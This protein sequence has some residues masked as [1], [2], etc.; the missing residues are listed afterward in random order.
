MDLL[1]LVKSRLQAHAPSLA[2]VEIVEDIEAL[3][4]GT[5]AG[6]GATFVAPYREDAQPN[7]LTAGGF[8][9]VVTVEFLTAF[10]IRIA[11]DSK[12]SARIAR[13]WALKTEIER[14]LAGWQ[15]SAEAEPIALVGGQGGRLTTNVT[16]YVHTWETTRIL[17]GQDL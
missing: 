11:D 16:T 10:Q 3:A 6:T 4:K 17:T 7:E 14:A 15:P 1:E 9:Q 13:F 2:S 12:G 5:A 8:R